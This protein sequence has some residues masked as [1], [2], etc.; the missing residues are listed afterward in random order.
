MTIVSEKS[1][2][3]MRHRFTGHYDIKG[4]YFGMS[5]FNYPEFVQNELLCLLGLTG[6]D[7][8]CPM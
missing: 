5:T 6:S 4:N 8:D 2:T 7:I 1:E 3:Y